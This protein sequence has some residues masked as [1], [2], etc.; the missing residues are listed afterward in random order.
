MKR[1]I[2]ASSLCLTIMVCF[3]NSCISMQV[4]EI[5][6][7][8]DLVML[9]L[10]SVSTKWTSFHFLHI[11][12]SKADIEAKAVSRLMDE[13]RK[14]GH[15]GNIEIRNIKI[16]S[17]LS[18]LFILPLPC[19]YGILADFQTITAT[20]DIVENNPQARSSNILQRR[21][22][23]ATVNASV[24]LAER[25]PENSTLAVLSIFSSE[26]DTSEFII[27][28]LEFNLVN[29]GKF[30]IVDRRR[31]DQIRNEQN[32]QLSGD[33]SDDSAVSIGHMI[34][35]TIVITGEISGAGSNQRL[36]LKAI[37]VETA[38]IITMVR[39]QL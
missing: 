8:E 21:M 15:S 34:G 1:N 38:Q 4:R 25:I 24:A 35:A 22:A 33:V 29:S 3:L 5:P 13:A 17:R 20:G 37:D 31:L 39:E 6:P 28:E 2:I 11:Q 9:V 7:E 18:P 19:A 30:R 36:V 32:F 26:S 27:G 14:M 23:E 12:P 16:E 10:G